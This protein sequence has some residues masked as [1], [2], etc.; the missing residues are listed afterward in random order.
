MD[1]N[2]TTK[3]TTKGIAILWADDMRPIYLIQRK[4]LIRTAWLTADSISSCKAVHP[5][6]ICCIY[7]TIVKRK[8]KE[9]QM[10]KP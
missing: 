5:D 2:A 3:Y 8:A 7:S 9:V 4:L 1:K 10:E 6:V